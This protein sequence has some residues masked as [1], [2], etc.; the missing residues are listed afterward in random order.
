MNP[1]QQKIHELRQE[2]VQTIESLNLI[3]FD[4]GRLEKNLEQNKIICFR[5]QQKGHKASDCTNTRYK[6]KRKTPRTNN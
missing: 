6:K 4:L 3:Y 2:L 5:C 1:E